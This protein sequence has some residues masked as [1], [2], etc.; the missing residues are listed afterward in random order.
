MV[1][2]DYYKILELN[3]TNVDFEE[4]KQAYRNQAKKYHPDRNKANSEIIIQ[5]INE[6]YRVLSDTN[7][8]RKYD[9]KWK[10]YI[11]RNRRGNKTYEAVKQEKTLK[12]E[13][14]SM[15]FG[16][17]KS[18]FNK[19]KDNTKSEGKTLSKV[20]GENIK[21]EISIN[22]KEGFSGVK[23]YIA[24]R[25]VDGTLQRIPIEI[26]IGIKDNDKIRV[27]GRGK[28]GINGGKNG[29]L[30]VN[31]KLEDD[32]KLKLEGINIKTI[33]NIYPW[34]AA[35][36]TTKKIEGI[37]ETMTLKVPAG[38]QSGKRFE[39]PDKGYHDGFGGRGNLFIDV[40]IV[41]PNKMSDEELE[42]Y[43]K[44]EKLE[45]K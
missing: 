42:L 25:D 33:T 31:I 28:P 18:K 7:S 4:I 30:F 39:V 37:N 5:D 16:D 10:V 36:G 2:K 26:P 35:L 41:M 11:E 9:R 45:N 43:R 15:F 6:A 40:N 20:R 22:L 29:D 8:K 24:L 27:I 21:T 3:N 32:K 34:E 19:I 23:K 44:L 14:Y 13:V 17:F 1:F 12:E 38:T